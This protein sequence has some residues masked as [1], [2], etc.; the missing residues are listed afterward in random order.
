[1]DR[2]NWLSL[3]GICTTLNISHKHAIWLAKRGFLPCIRGRNGAVWIEARF[4]DPTP[5]YAE[6]LRLGEALYGRLYPVPVDLELAGLLTIREVAEIMGWKINYARQ[7]AY[8]GKIGPVVKIGITEFYSIKDVRKIY[9]KRR[10]RGL[11]KQASP[12]LVRE[13]IDYFLKTTAEAESEVPSDAQFAEDEILQR[14]LVRMSKLK[15]PEREAAF[16]EFYRKVALAKSTVV[17]MGG[18]SSA[19]GR[20]ASA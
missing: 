19:S 10:G 14:K 4:L 12:F 17:P 7:F 20:D 11:S 1:M 2:A 8:K 15:S 18:D 5:E 16:A 9:W 6:K 13:L 3:T